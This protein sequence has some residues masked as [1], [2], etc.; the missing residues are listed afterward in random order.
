[1]SASTFSLG[2]LIQVLT[3]AIRDIRADNSQ[4]YQSLQDNINQLEQIHLKRSYKTRG[5]GISRNDQDTVLNVFQAYE[6]V[7]QVSL[8]LRKLLSQMGVALSRYN[9]LDYALYYKDERIYA[10]TQDIYNAISYGGIRVTGQGLQISVQKIAEQLKED[11]KNDARRKLFTAFSEHYASFKQYASGMYL[12]QNKSEFGVSPANIN[13]GHVAEAHE[14][15]LQEHHKDLFELSTKKD[16]IPNKLIAKRIDDLRNSSTL[17]E[18]H[19]D[20]KDKKENAADVWK[21]IRDSLGYQRGTVAGDVNA[22]QVKEQKEE[23]STTLKL[24]SIKNLRE[25]I[26]VYSA[27]LAKE[28]DIPAQRVATA[29]ALYMSD[30]LDKTVRTELYNDRFLLYKLLKKEKIDIDQFIAKYGKLQI[31]I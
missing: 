24:T 23:G 16:F 4:L 7:I 29:I 21:H 26:K 17:T 5:K 30:I 15:H 13:L 6:Q 25:G 14:R 12:Q 27:I 31:H 19:K 18:W 10:S 28:E 20:N 8:Q 3:T 11:L 9:E 22:T 1:M 2:D